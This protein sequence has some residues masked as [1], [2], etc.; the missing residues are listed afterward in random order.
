MLNEDK[1]RLMSKM[2]VFEVTQGRK[3]MEIDRYSKRDFIFVQ[4]IK[5]WVLSTIGFGMVFLLTLFLCVDAVAVILT[6]VSLTF[7]IALIVALYIICIVLSWVLA[8]RKAI[9]DYEEAKR[10][11]AR[12]RSYLKKLGDMYD[13]EQIM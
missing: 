11:M 7:V 2:A 6:A 13:S 12:Y 9:N 4:V 1:V 3:V 5:A 8:R 10:T